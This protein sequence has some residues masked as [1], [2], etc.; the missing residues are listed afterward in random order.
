MGYQ[1]L[2]EFFAFPAKFLFLDLGGWQRAARA[3]FQKKLEV[4]IFLNRTIKTAEQ[5]VDLTTFRLGCTPVVNLFEQ[6]AEPILL[7]PNRYEYPIVPDQ[8]YPQGMEV[9]SVESVSSVNSATNTTTEYLPFH[10]FNHARG[11]DERTYWHSTRRPSIVP[12]D[13]GTEVCAKPRRS[14]LSARACRRIKP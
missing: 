7:S 8:A 12:E 4:V 6:T 13:T 14:G 2:T 5:A 1:L 11:P 10:S 9:Y 3:G